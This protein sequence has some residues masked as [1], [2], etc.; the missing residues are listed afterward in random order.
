M[1]S[2]WIFPGF[3]DPYLEDSWV[4]AIRH[5]EA[6]LILEVDFVL[7]KSH[8]EYRA[9][10]PGEQYC[11]R[12]GRIRFERVT[13]MSWTR[14]RAM[15]ATDAAGEEDLG[16]LDEFEVVGEVYA[17]SGDFGSVDVVSERPTAELL[18]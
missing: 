8:P 13:A 2:Y 18:E 6:T 15:Q 1:A 17:I 11:F 10:L 4:L 9:P 14:G 16:S 3:E 12:R 7:R 5:G